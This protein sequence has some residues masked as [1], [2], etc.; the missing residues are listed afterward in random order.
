M[1]AT[2]LALTVLGL[3]VTAGGQ[4]RPPAQTVRITATNVERSANLVQ[5]RGNV[6][7]TVGA[8]IVTADEVDLPTSRHNPD[9]APS[10]IQVRGNVHVAFDPGTPVVIEP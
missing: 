10:V 7:M 8:A 4:T 9:G 5:Y 3:A 1:K 2:L 6:Q